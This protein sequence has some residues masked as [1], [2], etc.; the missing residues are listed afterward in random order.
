MKH[1]LFA[2]FMIMAT[3]VFSQKAD[4]S[5]KVIPAPSKF[6]KNF[7][8]KFV[9][10]GIAAEGKVIRTE[11]LYADSTIEFG[12]H[13]RFEYGEQN[14][15]LAER[16]YYTD[17]LTNIFPKNKF[18]GLIFGVAEKSNLRAIN[19]RIQAGGGVGVH[20]VRTP[21]SQLSITNAII[22]ENTDFDNKTDIETVRNSIRVKGKH[23]LIAKKLTFV[24]LSLYQPSLNDAENYRW[25][26]SIAL[27]VPFIEKIKFR[28]GLDNNYDNIVAEGKKNNDIRF[29][30]GIAIGN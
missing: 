20:L 26:S 9:T 21:N 11:F 13:P 19:T 8:Y 30:V 22:Y 12:T 7:K 24:H 29:T 10:D 14:G 28:M 27:E 15:Q 25:S 16:E 2:F 18:Y 17:L 5:K 3:A 23:I 1:Y 4:T 6:K